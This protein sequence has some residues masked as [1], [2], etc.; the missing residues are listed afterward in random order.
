MQKQAS[1]L[2][3]LLALTILLVVV[4]STPAV[5]GSF[6][7]S[8]TIATTD[9]DNISGTFV[10]GMSEGNGF[11]LI[12]N[13]MNGMD[14]GATIM[15]IAPGPYG[16]H[17][18]DNWLNPS[19]TVSG[20]PPYFTANGFAFE[21]TSGPD[22]GEIYS[23]YWNPSDN[24]YEGCFVNSNGTCSVFPVENLYIESEPSTLWV[25]LPGLLGAFAS[26]R[27]KLRI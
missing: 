19:G 16:G 7:F 22:T 5:A 4:G 20:M 1:V 21:V 9:G 25:L 10:T 3:P 13:I 6:P 26:L 23:A 8:F 11:Y 17:P 2:V 18:T 12:T 15:L 14:N 24:A 27:R